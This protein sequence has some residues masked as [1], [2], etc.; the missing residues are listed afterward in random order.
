MDALK[1]DK[2]DSIKG[3]NIACLIPSSMHR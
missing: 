1:V 2:N 3:R